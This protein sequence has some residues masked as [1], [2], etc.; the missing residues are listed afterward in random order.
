[1][2]FVEEELQMQMGERRCSLQCQELPK[3]KVGVS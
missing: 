1:M 3:D 2:E